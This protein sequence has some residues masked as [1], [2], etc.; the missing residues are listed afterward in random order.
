VAEAAHHLLTQ[1]V[2]L[3][4]LGGDISLVLLIPVYLLFLLLRYPTNEGL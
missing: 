1:V 4:D 3:G 2:E